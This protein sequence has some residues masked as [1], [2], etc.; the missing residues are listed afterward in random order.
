MLERII[1]QAKEDK[2]SSF[3]KANIP[4]PSS[5]T[6]I[7][8]CDS[9]YFLTCPGNSSVFYK[10]NWPPCGQ[11][12]G[13]FLRTLR[14]A[15]EGPD[16]SPRESSGH[17]ASCAER[18]SLGEQGRG[19]GTGE[20]SNGHGCGVLFGSSYEGIGFE[21]GKRSGCVRG[22]TTSDATLYLSDRAL[23]RRSLAVCIH[24]GDV[25]ITKML[26]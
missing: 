17:P 3:P 4:I 16:A 19:H 9:V 13:E 22:R 1:S 10:S 15:C 5:P 7:H 8:S 11:R 18:Q 24:R 12:N 21:N 14:A 26:P 2:V 6:S 25:A 20:S 23:S